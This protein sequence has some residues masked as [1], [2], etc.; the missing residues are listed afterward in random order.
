MRRPPLRIAECSIRK[1]CLAKP[2]EPEELPAK[3]PEV[4]GATPHAITVRVA[5]DEEGIRTLFQE[6]TPR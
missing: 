2:F 6:T 1:S 5:D 3:V 4:M